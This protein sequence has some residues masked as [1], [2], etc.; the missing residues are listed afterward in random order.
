MIQLALPRN[1]K[2]NLLL[3]AESRFTAFEDTMPSDGHCHFPDCK[4]AGL[5]FKRLDKHLKRCH[6]GK[7]MEDNFNCPLPNPVSR[8]LVKNTDRQRKPCTVP[9]CRYYGVPIARLER[10][11]KKVHGTKGQEKKDAVIEC[12]FSE[13]EESNDCFSAKIAGIINNL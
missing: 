8:T 4:Q 3:S 9:G 1:I 2:S 13:E 5:Y 11:S 12:S 10:H 6:P 7:T